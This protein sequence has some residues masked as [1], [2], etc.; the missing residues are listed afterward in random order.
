MRR[1]TVIFIVC[2]SFS[3]LV[4]GLITFND[5]V[6]AFTPSLEKATMQEK[7]ISAST[8]FLSSYSVALQFLAIYEAASQKELDYS[9]SISDIKKTLAELKQAQ[10]LYEEAK[11]IGVYLGYNE[12]KRSNF[13]FYSYDK[14]I[15]E[16]NL[17]SELAGEVR[18]YLE[19]MDIIGIYQKNIANIE[20]IKT[21]IDTIEI[22]LK[23]NR[24]PAI[25]LVW[26]LLQKYSHAILFGNYATIMGGEI[27]T[28]DG[29]PLCDPNG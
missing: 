7:M 23:E 14:A 26:K 19:R 10:A 24:R 22:E 13:T 28:Q 16:N 20:E 3:Y 1:N 29:P 18:M 12:L 17:N 5:I 2:M 4:M 8:K 27:L 11:Q 6:C 25:Q 15:L 9:S 21:I